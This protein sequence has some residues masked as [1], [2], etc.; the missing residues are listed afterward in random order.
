MPPQARVFAARS[1][2]KQNAGKVLDMRD[3]LFPNSRLL[4]TIWIRTRA[5][6]PL[7]SS[8]VSSVKVANVG[9]HQR[10]PENIKMTP[11]IQ[12]TMST[13][14]K[15]LVVLLAIA[16]ASFALSPAAQS[17][18]PSPTPDGGYPGNNTAEGY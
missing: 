10:E 11:S 8:P 12:L 14:T 2:L 15:R 5:L 13:S 17:Q 16:L 4:S 3:G 18:L 7:A 9:V 6:C 1:T